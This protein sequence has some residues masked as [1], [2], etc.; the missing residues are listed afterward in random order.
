MLRG[1]PVLRPVQTTN[2]DDNRELNH[3]SVIRTPTE[4]NVNNKR[5]RSSNHNHNKYNNNKV[6]VPI[7]S[8]PSSSG[9]GFKP[10]IRLASTLPRFLPFCPHTKVGDIFVVK[11]I[12]VVVPTK[13]NDG[14]EHLIDTDLWIEYKV[15]D[16]NTEGIE[17]T[18][19]IGGEGSWVIGTIIDPVSRF[20][21]AVRDHTQIYG[22]DIVVNGGGSLLSPGFV[23]LQV[24]GA[25]GIDFTSTEV[26][27]KQVQSVA[28]GL[29]AHGVTSFLPTI[30]TSTTYH[31]SIPTLASAA[32]K[33]YIYGSNI[34][35]IH[36]EGPFIHTMKK[37]A[38]PVQHIKNPVQGMRTIRETYGHLDMIKMVT[39]A[40]EL[41]G[42]FSAIS[43]LTTMGV[44]VS[45]GHTTTSLST[46]V[47]SVY[48]GARMITH[49]FNAMSA[50]HHRDPGLVG[51]LTSNCRNK[52]HYGIIVDGIHV[53]PTAIK[54]AYQR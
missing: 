28:E 19:I 15:I 8:T 14:N 1:S 9:G 48:Q 23:D 32:K 12:N 5:K 3:F 20:W 4:N 18:R 24:N 37:G 26:T 42:S 34:L 49:L 52:V 46:A 36:L 43:G 10:P 40:P 11:I 17:D 31:H 50:F 47:S 51:I 2:A 21:D 6:N 45:L 33:Q 41:Q 22:A 30:I 13:G 16:R 7:A 38:H 35:G 27:E 29:L 54:M 53:H 39:L 25:F 44:A